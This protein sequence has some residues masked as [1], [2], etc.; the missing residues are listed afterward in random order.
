M[1][2]IITY[3]VC[4]VVAFV[5]AQGLAVQSYASNHTIPPPGP[6]YNVN[7]FTTN[8]AAISNQFSRIGNFVVYVLISVAVIWIVYS[9][10]RYLIIGGSDAAARQEAGQKILWGIVGLF[11][12]LSIWGLVRILTTTFITGSNRAPAGDFPL[13]DIQTPR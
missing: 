7:A 10:V 11:I 3:V 8:T 13:I 9:V 6:D 1:K 4:L 12:I 2:K 5:F